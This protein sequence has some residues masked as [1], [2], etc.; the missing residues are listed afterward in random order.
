MF[1]YPKLK[2]LD[3][4]FT[5][6]NITEACISLM[7]IAKHSKWITNTIKEITAFSF[8]HLTIFSGSDLHLILFS[9]CCFSSSDLYL[10]SGWTTA[11]EALT[12]ENVFFIL[13]YLRLQRLWKGFVLSNENNFSWRHKETLITR[14]QTCG[15]R[16]S[17]VQKVSS[18]PLAVSW[19]LLDDIFSPCKLPGNN[20]Y[21][22]QSR[23][24]SN[25]T[26]F[27]FNT[28]INEQMAI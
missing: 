19:K 3:K 20:V 11:S 24:Y 22:G 14:R 5:S 16:L 10:V 13:C 23:L 27:L 15:G 9:L 17:S 18:S 4:M 7:S 26:G 12:F 28:P 6:A 21:Q 1:Q 25:H 2:T 8:V